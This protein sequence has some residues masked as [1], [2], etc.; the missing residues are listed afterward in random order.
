MSYK[1]VVDSCCDLT[2]SLRRE[3]AFTSVPLTIRL[4]NTVIV[5]DESF[6]QAK[7]LESMAQSETAPQS[8]CPAPAD[9]MDAYDCNCDELYV[10]TLSAALSG[11]HNSAQ[12]ARQLWLED[13][14]ESKIHVFDSRSASGGEVLIALKIREFAN[15]GLSFEEVIENVETFIS[16]LNTLF[17]L[18]NLDVLRKNGRLTGLTSVVT[19]AL[20]IKLFMGA[21][22]EGEIQKLGQAMSAKQALSKMIDFMSKDERHVG[23][24]LAISHCNDLDR[25]YLVRTMAE[26]ACQFKDFL[27]LDTGAL[28][29]IYANQSGIVACY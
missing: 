14:P 18:E 15:A 12:Q 13:H 28:S 8:A 7:L 29:T 5:D 26:K 2:P 3:D 19:N 22:D 4:G 25:A 23:K 21:T 16:E 11:S 9:Y 27:I 24:T 1:I 6:N 17:V 20:H 10:V